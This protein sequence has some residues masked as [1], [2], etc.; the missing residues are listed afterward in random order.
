MRTL[1]ASSH[2]AP[3]N[4]YS[5]LCFTAAKC[6]QLSKSYVLNPLL[7]RKYNINYNNSNIIKKLLST[8][9]SIA[10]ILFTP[11]TSVLST[12]LTS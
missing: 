10:L 3:L 7:I 9:R 12:L 8:T 6:A 2:M 4:P 11:L 1:I 5:Y